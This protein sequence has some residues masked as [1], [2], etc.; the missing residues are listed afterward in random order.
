MKYHARLNY[1]Q[2]FSV[3]SDLFHWTRNLFVASTWCP[4]G[5][6]C[7]LSLLNFI[8]KLYFSVYEHN[9]P[10]VIVEA[11][12]SHNPSNSEL[13]SKGGGGRRPVL[14][15]SG[16]ARGLKPNRQSANK[17]HAEVNQEG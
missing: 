2:T 17:V 13:K 3:R 16:G 7:L 8:C 11:F 12:S 10:Q 9:K 14:I 6:L 5:L 15:I 1:R 4:K